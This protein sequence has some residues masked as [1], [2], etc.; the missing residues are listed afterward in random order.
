MIWKRVERKDWIAGLG[1]NRQC[2]AQLSL[3]QETFIRRDLLGFSIR[4]KNGRC[5]RL[6]KFR[7]WEVLSPQEKHWSLQIVFFLFGWFKIDYFTRCDFLLEF[8]AL[9]DH[10]YRE[11]Y[12]AGT[13]HISDILDQMEGPQQRF[14]KDRL[15]NVLEISLAERDIFADFFLGVL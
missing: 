12:Q 13:H 2:Q 7:C 8:V 4:S 1:V 5:F 9:D 10:E 15:A 6:W 11:F 3:I 14:W